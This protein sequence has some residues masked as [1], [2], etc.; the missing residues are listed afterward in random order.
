MFL[1]NAC[2]LRWMVFLYRATILISMILES[3]SEGAMIW[4][5]LQIFVSSFETVTT[6]NL[7]NKTISRATNCF[8]V[9]AYISTTPAPLRWGY[10]SSA[11]TKTNSIRVNK[12]RSHEIQQ[13]FINDIGNSVYV[14]HMVVGKRAFNSNPERTFSA[15]TKTDVNSHWMLISFF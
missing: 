2:W 7:T 11:D 3:M 8:L 12:Y 4:L 14:K 10:A 9:T 5:F 13:L 1:C 15:P 6:L